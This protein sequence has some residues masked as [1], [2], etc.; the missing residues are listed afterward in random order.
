MGDSLHI[1]EGAEELGTS[2]LASSLEL[3]E[4]NVEVRLHRGRAMLRAWLLGRVGTK[5][6]NVF[7]FIRIR[8]DHIAH[9][10]LAQLIPQAPTLRS[11]SDD[12][13]AE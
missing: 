6:E 5:A 13:S 1:D 4:E 3:T 9:V 2:E 10:V 12:S 7:S 8:C 11:S